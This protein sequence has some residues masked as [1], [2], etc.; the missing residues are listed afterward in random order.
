[1]CPDQYPDTRGIP[2]ATACT[3]KPSSILRRRHLWLV[4]QLCMSK[5][6]LV[7]GAFRIGGVCCVLGT[8]T[9]VYRPLEGEGE[10]CELDVLCK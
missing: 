5:L 4:P 1:M 2:H 6:M 9:E 7:K 10:N 3:M 8:L